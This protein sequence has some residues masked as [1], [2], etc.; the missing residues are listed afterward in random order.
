MNKSIWRIIALLVIVSLAL[1]ACQPKA[2][3]APVVEDEPEVVEEGEPE[4]E[5]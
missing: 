2:T 4:E 1:V 3:E 5:A